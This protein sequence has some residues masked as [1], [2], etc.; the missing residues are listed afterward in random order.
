[1]NV[2]RRDKVIYDQPKTFEERLKVARECRKCLNVRM[3]ILVDG[4]D[5]A[6]CKAYSAAPVRCYLI[7]KDGRIVYMEGR[8]PRGLKPDLLAKALAKMFPPP[9]EGEK[10]G[11]AGAAPSN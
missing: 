2:N 6:V 10:A 1:M 3:P 9:R 4:I 8:G 5:N 11:E 7:G